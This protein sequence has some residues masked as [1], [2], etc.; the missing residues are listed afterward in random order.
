[1]SSHYPDPLPGD[2]DKE[3][4]DVAAS[5]VRI[6]APSRDRRLVVQLTVEGEE[7]ITLEQIAR[8][9]GETPSDVVRSLIRAASDKA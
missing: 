1:M 4:V 3:L 7:A 2:F 6:V 5:D 8:D 9:R